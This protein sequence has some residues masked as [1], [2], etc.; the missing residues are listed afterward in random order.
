LEKEFNLK[1][2]YC[3]NCSYHNTY[4]YPDRI[5]CFFKFQNK[6]NPIVS[7]F[8]CCDTWEFKTQECYCLKDALKK[9]KETK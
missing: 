2:K 7:V 3:G 6:D 5:F 9:Q 4:E 1:K 8:D